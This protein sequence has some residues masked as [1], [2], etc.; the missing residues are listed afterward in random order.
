VI[1]GGRVVAVL[2]YSG[3]RDDGLHHVCAARVVHAQGLAVGCRAVI[4]SGEAEV[5][6][7]AWRGPELALICDGDAR[8]TVENVVNVA[9]AARELGVEEV[10]AVT[11]RWHRLR[12]RILLAAA[13]RSSGIHSRVESPRASRP[14]L[15]VARELVA[16]AL[17]PVQLLRVLRA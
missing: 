11:S 13:L 17:L 2:G 8:S 7:A 9:A 3:R 14:L 6:R 4:L 15:L 5:M 10:V 12:V 1:E 16:L